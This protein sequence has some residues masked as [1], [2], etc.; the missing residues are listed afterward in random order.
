LGDDGKAAFYRQIAQ[1]DSAHT[2]EVQPLYAQITCPVLIL[3]GREDS[4]IPLERG[5]ALHDMIPGSML[6]VI[7]NAGHLVI[8]EEPI[9]L[10][11]EISS[12]IQQEKAT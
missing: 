2:D 6:R 10:I 11:K 5:E 1:S 8:E 12:F 3:W 7:P 9:Q 4:W